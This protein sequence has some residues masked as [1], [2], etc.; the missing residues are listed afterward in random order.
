MCVC[1]VGAG[2]QGLNYLAVTSSI[3]KGS[4]EGCVSPTAVPVLRRARASLV[5]KETDTDA[6]RAG[7]GGWGVWGGW[8]G[9]GGVGR[10][11]RM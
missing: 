9:G 10:P 11:P 8:A 6:V 5:E 2:A 1:V 4:P 7:W 3:M